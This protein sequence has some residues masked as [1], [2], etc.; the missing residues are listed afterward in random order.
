MLALASHRLGIRVHTFSPERDTPTGQ[1]AEREICASYDDREAVR[2]FVRGVDAV[3][4]E[5]ENVPAHVAEIAR[6]EGVA[7]R[8][9]G[10]VLHVAQNRLREKSF[11]VEAGLPVTPFAPVH[12]LANLQTALAQLGTPAVLKTAAFGYD[13]KGQVKIDDP[14]QAAAAWQALGGQAAIVESFVAFERELSVVAARGVDDTFAA[15]PLVE[16]RHINHILDV[17]IAPAQVS[18]EVAAEAERLTRRLMEVLDVVGVLCVEFFLLPEKN[19][20]ESAPSA[21]SA[22]YS[23]GRLLIN[24]IAPRPHNSGHWTIEGAVTSQF[25]QQARAVCALPLGSSEQLRP[26]AMVNLLGDLWTQGEPDWA[27]LLAYPTAKLHLY[28]KSAARPGRKMGHVTV[29]A[30]TVDEAL[31]I[32]LTARASLVGR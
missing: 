3:T 21:S 8:P 31:A 4:F 7:V 23:S 25:E 32:A 24:E 29:T 17:T 13:G 18:A 15:F 16:N 12:S 9:G 30:Q 2:S 10:H 28:G 19:P 5:F 11:L 20:R 1:V 26:A 14:A 27:A 22:F 6:E